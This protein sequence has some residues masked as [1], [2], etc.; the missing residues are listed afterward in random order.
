MKIIIFIIGA[1]IL[2]RMK[3]NAE[4]MQQENNDIYDELIEAGQ[5]IFM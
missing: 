1:L 4:E 2:R 3:N 5:N